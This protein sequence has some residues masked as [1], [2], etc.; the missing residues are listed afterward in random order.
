[1]DYQTNWT[2]FN[3]WWI[4]ITPNQLQFTFIVKNNIF[5]ILLFLKIKKNL[6]KILGEAGCDRTG[7]IVGNY[8]NYIII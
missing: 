5:F 8:K 4:L 7:E 6:N 1:M 2:N 3:K